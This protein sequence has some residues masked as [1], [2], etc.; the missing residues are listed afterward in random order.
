MMEGTGMVLLRLN[1]CRNALLTRKICLKEE[2]GS[3]L[4]LVVFLT[5]ALL[6]LGAVFLQGSLQERFIARNY[7][8]KIKAHYIAEAGVEAALS[9]L[10]KQ[11]DCFLHNS[12]VDPVYISNGPAEEYFTLEWLEPGNP[13]G[14]HDYYTLI[15]R[16]Y[17]RHTL[18]ERSAKA[19]I[20]MFVEIDFIEGENGDSEETSV[21]F[22]YLSGI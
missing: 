14:H 1:Y 21:V 12:M 16:G 6:L 9:L 19:V 22:R 17:Y 15:S 5:A 13:K 8:Q 20:K 4:F 2:K 18:K 7:T 10:K 11:P 3:I